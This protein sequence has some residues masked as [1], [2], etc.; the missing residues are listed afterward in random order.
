MTV[1]AFVRHTDLGENVADGEPLRSCLAQY[2]VARC[3]LTKEDLRKGLASYSLVEFED[4]TSAAVHVSKQGPV[5][6]HHFPKS[7]MIACFNSW[8]ILIAND[9]S[10]TSS[11]LC[12]ICRKPQLTA[13]T[14]VTQ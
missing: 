13:L 5:M 10:Y 14:A 6:P 4:A 9:R 12:G 7:H 1:T 3:A 11:C 8:Q 2:N